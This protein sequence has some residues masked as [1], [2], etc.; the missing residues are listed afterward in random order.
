MRLA[1]ITDIHEDIVS[2][3]RI[4]ARIHKKGYDQLICLGD[5]SGFSLPYYK[6]PETRNA[7][8][9]LTLLK[10]QCNIIIPGNHDLH[11]A[12]KIPEHSDVFSFPANWYDLDMAHRKELAG[13]EL[14]LHADDLDYGYQADDLEY[15]RGLPEFVI[16]ETPKMNI[17]LSHYAA[18]NLSGFRKPFYTWAREFGHHFELM[19]QHD[20]QLSFIGHAHP[21]GI[22]EVGEIRFKY[23]AYRKHKLKNF[24]AIIGCPPASRHKLRQGF[25]IFDSDKMMIK[26]YR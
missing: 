8:A 1:I 12:K 19:G 4:L 26:A 7:R 15:L 23:F 17:F 22:F 3:E 20:C 6:Y 13:E 5:I 25:S 18:P 24:P 9:C 16:L 21:K 14:W 10:E 11:A 2:L